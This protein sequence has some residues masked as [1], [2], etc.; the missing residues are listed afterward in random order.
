M[1]AFHHFKASMPHLSCLPSATQQ[2]RHWPSLLSQ[3]ITAF[4]PLC[5]FSRTPAPTSRA[6]VQREHYRP[7]HHHPMP[8][9]ANAFVRS[10]PGL[11]WPCLYAAVQ[12]GDEGYSPLMA[13][14]PDVQDEESSAGFLELQ[15]VDFGRLSA[16]RGW[17]K[18]RVRKL[19]REEVNVQDIMNGLFVGDWGTRAYR[20]ARDRARGV[21]GIDE[22]GV[23]RRVSHGHR[24]RWSLARGRHRPTRPR[25][26]RRGERPCR[27]YRGGRDSAGL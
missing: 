9:M 13:R 2:S 12:R 6:A 8:A 25:W 4:P 21:R 15:S 27:G 24:L 5:R 14:S 23:I 19:T 1:L 17:R 18:F 22:E 16:F 26:W 10:A 7:L 20:R 3:E 11:P